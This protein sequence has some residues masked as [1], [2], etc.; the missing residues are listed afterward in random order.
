MYKNINLF[1][2]GTSREVPR[3]SRDVPGTGLGDLEGPVVHYKKYTPCLG[4]NRGSSL[5][6]GISYGADPKL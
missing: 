3:R 1:G 4:I 6:I 2:P 5:F